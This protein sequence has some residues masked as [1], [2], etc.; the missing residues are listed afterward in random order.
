MEILYMGHEHPSDF[1]LINFKIDVDSIQ[2][3]KEHKPGE[4][5]CYAQLMAECFSNMNKLDKD[6]ALKYLH[7]KDDTVG[8]DFPQISLNYNCY[9]H[10][11]E[12][13]SLPTMEETT[14]RIRT[15]HPKQDVQEFELSFDHKNMFHEAKVLTPNEDT[16]SYDIWN[17]NDIHPKPGMKEKWVK[18]KS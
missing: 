17:Y 14:I 3:T 6:E 18:K 9:K 4:L 13:N 2:K 11:D 7:Q 1:N 15:F 10:S 5:V 12:F 8:P 16:F